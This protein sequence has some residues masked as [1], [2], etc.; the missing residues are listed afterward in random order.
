MEVCGTHTHAIAENGLKQLLPEN[1]KLIS[2]PGCPVC[3]T[4]NSA[5][6]KMIALTEQAIV[7]TFGDM[8]RVPGSSKSLQ[9]CNN[10]KIVY[11]PMDAVEIAKSNPDREVVFLG[12]GFET[13]VPTTAVAIK[14]AP[15]NFS[16]FCAH[17]NMPP[18]LKM[19]AED[20]LVD[21]LILPGHVSTIIGLE[22]YK[23]LLDY[24]ISGVV[25]GFDAKDIILAIDM[26]IN[27]PLGIY[28]AYPRGVKDKG[29]VVAQ[30]LID[31]YF[32]TCD[33]EWRGLGVLPDSGYKIR[34]SRYDSQEKFQ[35]KPEPT[36]E[37]PA[38][39][40]GDILQGKLSP[41]DCPL[42]GNACTPQHPVGPCMVSSEGSCSAWWKSSDHNI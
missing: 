10:V 32:V 13:T 24:G 30:E 11:S 36:K 7:C 19:I 6:D 1:V 34:D 29:N 37:N 4:P 20:S 38:C 39:K 8:M 15:D 31:S 3:V 21:G 17:K 28:N 25:A 41:N 40:C 18:A 26:L 5:I 9:Q 27:K 23:F 14:N 2:G 35:I 16:V 12:V 33:S 22:P 42:F